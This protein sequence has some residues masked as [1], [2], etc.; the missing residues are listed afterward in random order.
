MYYMFINIIIITCEEF[1]V[2]KEEIINENC[3]D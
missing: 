1:P 2:I 3:F